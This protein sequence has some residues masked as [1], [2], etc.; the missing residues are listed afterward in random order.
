MIDK[1]KALPFEM[2]LLDYAV[3]LRKEEK[4]KASREKKDKE[5]AEYQRL[6]KKFKED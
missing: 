3:S 2:Y 5:F 6:K 1:R 4:A